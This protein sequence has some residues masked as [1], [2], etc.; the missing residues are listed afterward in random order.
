M[1]FLPVICLRRGRLPESSLESPLKSDR[2]FLLAFPEP[3]LQ[4]PDFRAHKLSLLPV[5]GHEPRNLVKLLLSLRLKLPVSLFQ[6]VNRRRDICLRAARLLHTNQII[7]EVLAQP[8]VSLGLGLPDIER[9]QKIPLTQAARQLCE[10]R[11]RV[12]K[13]PALCLTDNTKAFILLQK[14]PLDPVDGIPLVHLHHTCKIVRIV[15]W[16][17]K[18][19]FIDILRSCFL[20]SVQHC[21]DKRKNR[22]LP[23]FISALYNVESRMK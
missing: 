13:L 17:P 10:K 15:P 1:T 19:I 8:A 21:T 22:T 7:P 4:T 5:I 3:S 6:L 23:G 18:L 2:A 20:N 14:I 11:L 16:L 12:L 9:I